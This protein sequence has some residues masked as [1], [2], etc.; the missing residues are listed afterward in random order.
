MNRSAGKTPSSPVALIVDDEADIREL[1][2]ITLLRMGVRTQAAAN[3]A[4]ARAHLAER[5]FHF[6]FT[7]M[8]LP[9]G[10]GIDLVHH[11]QKHSPGLPVAVITAYGNA[12]AAVE[13]LKAGAFDFVSKP[14]DLPMLRKLVETGLRLKAG[15]GEAPPADGGL[16]GR[17]PSVDQLRSLI[18]R[19][20]RSQAPVH[21]CGESGT[22]KELVARLIHQRGPRGSAAF[23]PVNCGAIP[24]ELMESE[25]FGHLKGSFTGAL[26]DKSGLFQAAEGGTLFLDEVADLPLHMQVKLLRALQERRVRPVGSESEIPVNVRVISATHRDLSGLVASGQFRQDLYYRLNVIEVR[27]PALRERRGDIPLLAASILARLTDGD[28]RQPQLTADALAQLMAYEFPGNVRELENVLE[29]AITLSDG[30][31]I[32]AADLQLRPTALTGVAPAAAAAAPAPV[33][34]N[35]PAPAGLDTQIEQMEKRAIR[36]A[37]EKARYNKTRAAELLGLSFRQLRYKLKKFN[38]E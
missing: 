24:S 22:G 15:D 16:L 3:L 4:E 18:E 31:S 14:V 33:L 36:D 1:I 5:S 30:A 35:A 34:G 20:A 32:G 6:C 9:D 38:I 27:T 21:I 13:S 12:Q 7:D 2:E 8:R 25:F 19:L 23:V 37:L 29:R 26:R 10:S 28:G 11:V 17:D